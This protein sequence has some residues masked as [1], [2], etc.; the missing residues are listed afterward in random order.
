MISTSVIVAVVGSSGMW[1]LL[2]HFLDVKVKKR[3]EKLQCLS[4]DL[5]DIKTALDSAK[6]LS[7]C[8][9]RDRTNYLSNRY[10]DMGYIPLKDADSFFEIGDCYI[11]NGG[12]SS[13]KAKFE[14]AK[15]LE[16]KDE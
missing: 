8:T 3:G 11:S 5:R 4:D 1:G 2:Q 12:N 6:E 10:L 16:I 14:K 7:M 9:A 15:Q 13:V